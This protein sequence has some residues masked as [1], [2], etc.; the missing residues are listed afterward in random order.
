MVRT[1]LSS[2]HGA[3]QDGA[4]KDSGFGRAV[5]LNEVKDLPAAARSVPEA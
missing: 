5:I 1:T 4:V 3:N 2:G